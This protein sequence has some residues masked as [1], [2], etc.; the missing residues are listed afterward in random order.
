MEL[1]GSALVR[2]LMLLELFP[3]VLA[4]E[5]WGMEFTNRRFRFHCDDLGVVQAIN[6]LSASSLPVVRLLRHLV[7][8]CLR[9][10]ICVSAVHIHAVENEVAHALSRLQWEGFRQLA[11]GAEWLG[12]PCPRHMWE[13]VLIP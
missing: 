3:I 13:L 12:V 4:V 5:L 10:N 7:L 6:S 2:N 11:L 8:I 9:L 1:A